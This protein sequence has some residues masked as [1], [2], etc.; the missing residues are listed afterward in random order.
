MRRDQ[1]RHSHIVVVDRAK[2]KVRVK[3]TINPPPT[4]QT[5][6]LAT[7]R[8]TTLTT[9]EISQNSELFEVLRF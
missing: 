5:E 7:M 9:G 4:Y 6:C 8:R 3:V 2:V 1:L